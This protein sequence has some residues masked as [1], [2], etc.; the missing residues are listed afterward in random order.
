MLPYRWLHFYW[1]GYPVVRLHLQ[2]RCRRYFVIRDTRYLYCTIWYSIHSG[3]PWLFNKPFTIRSTYGYSLTFV[4]GIVMHT[5][6]DRY[7][8][9]TGSFYYSV[10]WGLLHTLYVYTFPKII[11]MYYISQKPSPR[12]T[13]IT[14]LL[15]IHHRSTAL[16][17]VMCGTLNTFP[18]YT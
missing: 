11:T 15:I 2:E 18:L 6:R 12:Y 13:C 1:C 17:I 10:L 9:R 16:C 5:S 14:Q 7:I 3:E 4:W 8:I